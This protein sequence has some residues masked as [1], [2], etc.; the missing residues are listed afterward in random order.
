MNSYSPFKP[1]AH[2]A[3]WSCAG[4]TLFQPCGLALTFCPLAALA[5]NLYKWDSPCPDCPIGHWASF[6][7]VSWLAPSYHP[8]SPVILFMGQELNNYFPGVT[9]SSRTCVSMALILVVLANLKDI[10][11]QQKLYCKF[12]PRECLMCAVL[13]LLHPSGC[14]HCCLL[15]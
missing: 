15:T 9:Y 1:C 8:R 11:S 12:A 10:P 3:P 5:A 7:Q 13:F 4:T 2:I 14:P 6:R